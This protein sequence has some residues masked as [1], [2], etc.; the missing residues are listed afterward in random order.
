MQDES[1]STDVHA[2]WGATAAAAAQPR[3]GHGHTHVL[4]HLHLRRRCHALRRSAHLDRR[5]RELRVH[6]HTAQHA[7]R[8]ASSAPA[9]STAARDHDLQDH[10]P[11]AHAHAGGH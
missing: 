5:H 11:A 9:P 3:H 2:N 1:G 10:A 4:L 8:P 6:W 7:A